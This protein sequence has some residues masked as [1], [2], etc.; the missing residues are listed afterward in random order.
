LNIALF[1][2]VEGKGS[3]YQSLAVVLGITPNAVKCR[4]DDA[5]WRYPSEDLDPE[6]VGLTAADKKYLAARIAQSEDPASIEFA[7]KIHTAR[8]AR[9]DRRSQARDCPES[10]CR[11]SDHSPVES[12]EA[13]RE[14]VAA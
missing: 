14:M 12:I 9:P 3:V 6:M 8:R 10:R 7:A 2:I 5:R 4:V 13:D 1:R 11:Q